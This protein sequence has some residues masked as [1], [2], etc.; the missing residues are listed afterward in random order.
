MRAQ[1][2]PWCDTVST[3]WCPPWRRRTLAFADHTG[4]VLLFHSLR[5]CSV[6]LVWGWPSLTAPA[7]RRRSCVCTQVPLWC[8]FVRSSLV[9]ALTELPWIQR[10]MRATEG[11]WQSQPTARRRRHCASAVPS[12]DRSCFEF[13]LGVL[14]TVHLTLAPLRV[15]VIC[16]V[17]TYALASLSCFTGYS[18]ARFSSSFIGCAPDLAPSRR[19][20][21]AGNVGIPAFLE[22]P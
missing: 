13:V 14:S 7:A 5:T 15:F 3:R 1:R 12:H 8:S 18:C 4:A 9:S 6:A 2:R 11:C 22:Y 19:L 21:A 16:F 10:C 20:L 17:Y